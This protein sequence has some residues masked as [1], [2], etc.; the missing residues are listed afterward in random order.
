MPQLDKLTFFNQFL[1]FII[2]I[3]FFYTVLSIYTLPELNYITLLRKEGS[4]NYIFQALIEKIS[5]FIYF[6]KK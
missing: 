2:N 4:K 6:N 5:I 1:I 3:F